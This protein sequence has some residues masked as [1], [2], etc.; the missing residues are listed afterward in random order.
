MT[1]RVV[2]GNELVRQSSQNEFYVSKMNSMTQ[3]MYFLK[4]HKIQFINLN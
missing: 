1:S 2:A 4:H 3:F